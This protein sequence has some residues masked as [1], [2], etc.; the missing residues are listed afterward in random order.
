M[1]T[2]KRDAVLQ[3]ALELFSAHTFAGTPVPLIAD[4]AGVGAGTI[5]RYFTDKEDLGNAVYQLWA[6]ELRGRLTDAAPSGGSSRD[7]LA[8]WWQAIVTFATEQAAAFRFLE[9]Q[10]HD[11]YL[12]ADSRAAAAAVDAVAL[13]IVRRGQR[14]GEIR[15]ADAHL[16]VA[17]LRGAATGLARAA[18][19]GAFRPTRKAL[20]D[21]EEAAW[22]LVAA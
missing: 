2:T 22:A 5:Y 18:R 21:A 15:K 16:L 19:T 11:A 8:Q 1:A 12:D 3:A 7:E 13:A 6:E 4:H 14:R 17:L 9:D 10:Q 20:T